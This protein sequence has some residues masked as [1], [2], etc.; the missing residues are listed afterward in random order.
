MTRRP[1]G[2]EFTSHARR[3][4]EARIGRPARTVARS[5][6]LPAAAKAGPTPSPDGEPAWVL[7]RRRS[8]SRRLTWWVIGAVVG[9]SAAVASLINPTEQARVPLVTEA[10]A[11]ASAVAE[12]AGLAA[13]RFETDTAVLLRHGMPHADW[14]GVGWFVVRPA[15]ADTMTVANEV[16]TS[17][18]C[19]AHNVTDRAPPRPGSAHLAVDC[20]IT[21]RIEPGEAESASVVSRFAG[22]SLVIYFRHMDPQ[23]LERLRSAVDALVEDGAA[24]PP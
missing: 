2:H 17:P 18:S 23:R 8:A 12:R 7:A 3:L 20:A 21:V 22:E 24:G 5:I 15:S 9:L 13:P 10:R 16:R 14:S 11:F 19:P 1:S 6:G 4:D